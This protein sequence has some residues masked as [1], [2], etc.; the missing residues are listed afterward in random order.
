MK[1]FQL[2]FRAFRGFRGQFAVKKK[3]AANVR[4]KIPHTDRLPPM[5]LQRRQSPDGGGDQG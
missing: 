3:G 4:K 1:F 2:I 5:R